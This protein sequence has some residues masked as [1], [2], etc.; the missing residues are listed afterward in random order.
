MS[1]YTDAIRGEVF[2]VPTVRELFED[3]RDKGRGTWECGWDDIRTANLGSEGRAA[4]RDY[5]KEV[6]QWKCDVAAAQLAVTVS[7]SAGKNARSPTTV[8]Q[9][10]ETMLAEVAVEYA[11]SM[12]AEVI[13]DH[14]GPLQEWV[15]EAVLLRIEHAGV[16]I[17]D[18]ALLPILVGERRRRLRPLPISARWRP[19]QCRDLSRDLEGLLRGEGVGVVSVRVALALELD[20]DGVGEDMVV[21]VQ[22]VRPKLIALNSPADAVFRSPK[23]GDWHMMEALGEMEEKL[24]ARKKDLEW[25]LKFLRPAAGGGDAPV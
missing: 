10:T 14:E 16:T 22:S 7:V 13:S 2:E 20:P 6:L 24:A 15:Q 23:S 17:I 11:L 19:G 9:L 1:W 3:G 5:V 4:L 25:Q 12:G 21:E 8:A 18:P